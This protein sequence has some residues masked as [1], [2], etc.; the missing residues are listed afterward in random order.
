MESQKN[1]LIK[2]LHHVQIS[3]GLIKDFFVIFVVSKN[4][5]KLKKYFN[6]YL[7]SF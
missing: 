4:V 3:T 1:T 7:M 5:N 6:E 2:N